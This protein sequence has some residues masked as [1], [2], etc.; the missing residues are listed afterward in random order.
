[1][2]NKIKF[3][4]SLLAGSALLTSCLP[5]PADERLVYSGPTVVEFKNHTLGMQNA[6]LDSKGIFRTSGFTQTDSSRVIDVMKRSQDTVLV[7]LIG[8]QRSTETVIN[9]TFATTSPYAN[10]PI[11]VKGTDFTVKSGDG[12]VTIP[13]NSSVGRIILDPL[14]DNLTAGTQKVIG[15]RLMGNNEVGVATNFDTFWLRIRKL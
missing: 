1:M 11:A 5:D 4:F 3:F 9:Y 7:Q 8:P 14:E 10:V 2:K 6:T 12:T 15:L 13:A